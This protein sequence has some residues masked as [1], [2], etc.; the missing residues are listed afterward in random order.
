MPNAFSTNQAGETK[1]SGI[2]WV[3][4]NRP[5]GQRIPAI[6]DPCREDEPPPDE[7]VIVVDDLLVERRRFGMG[8][9]D[10]A[11][12]EKLIMGATDDAN[13]L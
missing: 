12:V 13:G 1:W 3:E 6:R 4:A 11:E 8:K 10:L 2:S 9:L 7:R 5:T